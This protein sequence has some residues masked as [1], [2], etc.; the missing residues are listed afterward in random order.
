[1]LENIFSRFKK[2][3]SQTSSF[4]SKL[5]TLIILDGLGINPDPLGNAVA[6]A[7]TPFLDTIW[8]NGKTCLLEAS[9]PAVGLPEG[10]PGNSE[11]GHLNIGTGQIVYQSLP[12]IN[13]DIANGKFYNKQEILKAIQKVKQR[14]SRF[15]IMGILSNG[16]VHGHINHLYAILEVCRAHRVDPYL[17]IF[18]DGRD[19]APTD[20]YFFISKLIEKMR[21]E[22]VGQIASIGGRMWGMDRDKRWERTE[23]AF[24]AM[25][26]E[27]ERKSSDAFKLLQ[28][29]YQKGENDQTLIPTTIVNENNEPVGDIR[30]GDAVFFFNFREDRARQITKAFVLPDFDHFERS[31]IFKDLHFLT[32]TGYEDGLPCRVLYAPTKVN[33]TIARALEEKGM[34]Q[35]HI[36]ET[37]KAMHVTYFFNGGIEEPHKNEDS[38]TIP[39]PPVF[40]YSEVPAMSADIVT[41]EILYKFKHWDKFNYS[42]IVVNYANP[43]MLGHTGNLPAAIKSVEHVDKCVKKVVEATIA[44]GGAVIVTSD[45]GNCETMIDRST[46]SVDTYHNVAPVPFIFIKD[47]SELVVEKGMTVLKLGTG[48]ETI[49][50]GLLSDIAPTV[51]EVLGVE[52]LQEMTGV[53]LLDVI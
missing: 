24:K 16:G 2:K 23:K 44:A 29:A 39:S 52:P 47:R 1:M 40:D 21:Q 46:M 49:S 50:S 48:K 10:E 53:N 14:K 18:T 5:V 6:Q 19:T 42:F 9:G 13:D 38:M 45:H 3:Q 36:S 11:V 37:E 15:H 33:Q 25:I 35:L 28:R 34:S 32:M 30:D 26:G 31:R 8:T 51:L 27:G 17:H 4:R 20:G 43:D 12:H 22:G 41:D 7:K